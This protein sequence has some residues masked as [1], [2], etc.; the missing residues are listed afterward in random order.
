MRTILLMILGHVLADFTLQG[1]LAS[2]KSK[3]YWKGV[4]E[5]IKPER[6][7]KYRNNWIPALVCHSLF[8][9]IVTILPLYESAWWPHLVIV[10]ATLHAFIDHAKANCENVSLTLSQDQLLHLVQIVASYFLAG[11]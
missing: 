4:M 8:W 7:E 6:R 9:A 11:I 1:W 5:D 2:A 3:V 10:N